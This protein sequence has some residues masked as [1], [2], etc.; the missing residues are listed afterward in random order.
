VEPRNIVIKGHLDLSFITEELLEAT[1]FIESNEVA[2]ANGL[3]QELN[4][5][6]PLSYKAGTTTVHQCFDTD[7]PAWAHK[8]K[9]MFP[10]L[11]HRLVTVNKL[12]PGC[13][14]P[15][16]K[17]MFYRLKDMT[18]HVDTSNSVPIRINVLLQDKKYGHFLD[19]DNTA[20]S[21]YRKG[22]YVYIHRGVIHSVV[23]VGFENRYTLQVT[24]LA[25]PGVL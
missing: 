5:P 17:D 13:F 14:I 22:D 12:A 20:L 18:A 15:P 3:W 8:I 19:V 24:G 21:D 1:V 23:N 25:D 6:M 10:W 9:D 7:C 16:H 2:Y 11:Q 4:I